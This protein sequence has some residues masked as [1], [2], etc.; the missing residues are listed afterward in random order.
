MEDRKEVKHDDKNI[1]AIRYNDGC[2]VLGTEKDF[3]N[4]LLK[5]KNGK[6]VSFIKN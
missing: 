1:I 4:L 5:K 3:G 6:K 2:E